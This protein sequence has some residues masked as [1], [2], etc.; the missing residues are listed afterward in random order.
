MS[1][2]TEV[3]SSPPSQYQG[4]S[5]HPKPQIVTSHGG[6]QSEDTSELQLCHLLTQIK[7]LAKG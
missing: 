7:W 5:S 2:D 3:Q 4:I 6:L 1:S